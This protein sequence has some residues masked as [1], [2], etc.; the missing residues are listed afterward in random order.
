VPWDDRVERSFYQRCIGCDYES[1]KIVEEGVVGDK[2]GELRLVKRTTSTEHVPGDVGGQ[3]RWL[4]IRRP[5]KWRGDLPPPDDRP[6]QTAAEMRA[7]LVRRLISWGV[8][9]APLDPP[10]IEAKPKR[11]R[12]A[13]ASQVPITKAPA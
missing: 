4:A 12:G 6:E 11:L 10:L 8:K 9:L 3:S 1:V 2:G 7:E 5:N 13:P